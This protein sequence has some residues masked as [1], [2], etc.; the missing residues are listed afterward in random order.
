MLKDHATGKPLPGMNPA[1][2]RVRSGRFEAAKG[3]PFADAMNQYIRR[4]T[5]I[6]A[7]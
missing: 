4:D 5:P 1:S 6:A 2:Y 3:V 7:E